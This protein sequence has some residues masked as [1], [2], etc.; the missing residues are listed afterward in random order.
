MLPNNLELNLLM[1][2]LAHE[3]VVRVGYLLSLACKRLVLLI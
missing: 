3:G 2:V 1:Y